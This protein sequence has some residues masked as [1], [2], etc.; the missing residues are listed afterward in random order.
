MDILEK[1]TTYITEK[2]NPNVKPNSELSSMMKSMGLMTFGT[3][4]SGYSYKFTVS[5]DGKGIKVEMG[6]PKTP[7]RSTSVLY[8]F[9][10]IDEFEP[11]VT[12]QQKSIE[13]DFVKGVKS[14]DKTKRIKIKQ[15][16]R[17]Y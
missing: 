1:L 17:G 7:G 13:K 6:N 5:K 3:K 2:W 9:R 15:R 14:V 8:A 11:S 10:A 4:K 12:P 16:K